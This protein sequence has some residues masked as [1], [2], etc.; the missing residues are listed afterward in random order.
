[1]KPSKFSLSAKLYWYFI[2]S[3]L[4]P[5]SSD[6]TD[7][8]IWKMRKIYII[9]FQFWCSLNID[10]EIVWP[11]VHKD[12]KSCSSSTKFIFKILTFFNKVLGNIK[13]SMKFETWKRGIIFHSRKFLSNN[14]LNHEHCRL[15]ILDR[16]SASFKPPLAKLLIS[17]FYDF[18]SFV[19]PN[20][21][22]MYFM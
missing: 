6:K 1:M 20:K 22:F 15:V 16:T 10:I 18:W 5:P 12:R 21:F 13:G 14:L 3:H 9:I 19:I 4:C 8:M 17:F 2:V 11:M 7:T